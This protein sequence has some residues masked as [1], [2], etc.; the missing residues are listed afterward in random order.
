[1]TCQRTTYQARPIR[2]N[3]Q[4]CICPIW[5]SV[6]RTIFRQHSSLPFGFARESKL[7]HHGDLICEGVD[8]QN[9]IMVAG[10]AIHKALCISSSATPFEGLIRQISKQGNPGTS[11]RFNLQHA[12]CMRR[13]AVDCPIWANSTTMPLPFPRKI[14][15][16]AHLALRYLQNFFCVV[17][18]PVD[19]TIVTQQTTIPLVAAFRKRSKNLHLICVGHHPQN[20]LSIAGDAVDG[21]IRTQNTSM[22]FPTTVTNQAPSHVPHFAG[23]GHNL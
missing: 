3:L 20:T 7:L 1:M 15:K 11:T 18:D 6:D 10:K 16:G 8:L 2:C 12:S 5:N 23:A 14:S 13:D 22:P 21:A 19:G 9:G 4:H 17:W